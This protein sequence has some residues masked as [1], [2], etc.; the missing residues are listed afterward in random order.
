MKSESFT[1]CVTL[2]FGFGVRISCCFCDMI[3]E[4]IQ[5][6]LADVSA[7]VVHIQPEQIRFI[8]QFYPPTLD[9][10]LNPKCPIV[11]VLL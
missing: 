5:Y 7:R 1:F 3:S 8:Q 9:L 6:R 4:S 11:R 10:S 2:A